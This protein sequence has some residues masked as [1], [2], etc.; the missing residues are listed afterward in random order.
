M[1]ETT[2]P[3]HSIQCIDFSPSRDANSAFLFVREEFDPV[4]T[5]Q[6]LICFSRLRGNGCISNAITVIEWILFFDF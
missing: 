3:L 4:S 2:N 6:S 1:K 5:S